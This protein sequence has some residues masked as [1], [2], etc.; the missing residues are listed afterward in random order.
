M[1]KKQNIDKFVWHNGHFMYSEAV[2]KQIHLSKNRFTEKWTIEEGT[3]G[4]QKK[5]HIEK[6]YFQYFTPNIPGWL[7]PRMMI[8][9]CTY[10]TWDRY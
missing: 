2:V 3:A 5:M 1:Y 10:G 7:L 6:P 8:K 4:E 9:D